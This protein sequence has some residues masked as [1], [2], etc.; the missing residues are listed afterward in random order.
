MPHQLK[1]LK[2]KKSIK[3]GVLVNSFYTNVAVK[4]N[5]SNQVIFLTRHR[6]VVNLE[7][8]KLGIGL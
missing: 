4:F 3:L 6:P 7:K 5:H 2:K 8:F 1:N